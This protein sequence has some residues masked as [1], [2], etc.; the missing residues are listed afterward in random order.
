MLPKYVDCLLYMYANANPIIYG[1]KSFSFFEVNLILYYRVCLL[2]LSHSLASIDRKWF[3]ILLIMNCS[4]KHL[5]LLVV[6]ILFIHTL[7]TWTTWFSCPTINLYTNRT[8][9]HSLTP[10]LQKLIMGL[11]Y[12]AIFQV[13][14]Q[15]A[16]PKYLITTEFEVSVRLTTART[17]SLWGFISLIYDPFNSHCR[18][19]V[20]FGQNSQPSQSLVKFNSANTSRFGSSL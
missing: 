10:A 6:T 14:S 2:L 17:R 12:L 1:F 8:Y 15:W 13:G 18:H 3:N 20:D 11:I 5:Q 7:L 19:K 9:T 16:P 4:L